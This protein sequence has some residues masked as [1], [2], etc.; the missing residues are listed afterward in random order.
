MASTLKNNLNKILQ[1]KEQK[2]L[3][4]N[5]RQGVTILGVEGN[6]EVL[7]TSDANAVASNLAEGK[8]AYV[9]GEK[10]TGTLPVTTGTYYVDTDVRISKSAENETMTVNG[11]IISDRILK[12]GS[13]ASVTTDYDD[14]VSIIGLRADEIKQGVKYLNVEGSF[15]S[16]DTS[17]A[18]AVA[19]DLLKDKIA[20]VNGEK[21]TGTLDTITD[22][23]RMDASSVSMPI[24]DGNVVTVAGTLDK[25]GI[26]TDSLPVHINTTGNQIAAAVG[27]TPDII[28]VGTNVMG[29]EGTY[30]A[31]DSSKNDVLSVPEGATTA[32]ITQMLTSLDSLDTSGLTSGVNLFKDASQLKSVPDL[33]TGAMTSTIRMFSGCNNLISMG[34]LNL[35]KS[36]NTDYMFYNC[37][38][39]QRINLIAPTVETNFIGMFQGCTNLLEI[40]VLDYTRL[41]RSA[42][43]HGGSLVNFCRDCTS[44]TFAN[45]RHG[46]AY[47]RYGFQYSGAFYNCVNLL[48]FEG[49]RVSSVS[50]SYLMSCDNMF[51]NCHKLQ[52]IS[53]FNVYGAG[54]N[55]FCLNC[56]NLLG[57]TN[58]N[59]WG[60]TN[61]VPCNQAFRNC[62]NLINLP[63]IVAFR[64]YSPSHYVFGN[65][66]NLTFN[67]PVN[68][69][70][71][72]EQS[73][74]CNNSS[75]MFADCHSATDIHLRLVNT[76]NGGVFVH[77]M[78]Y[79]CYN[80]VNL[81]IE[82]FAS[83]VGFDNPFIG[84]YKLRT[85]NLVNTN[86]Q[87]SNFFRNSCVTSVANSMLNN[88]EPYI[89]RF[90]A[91]NQYCDCYNLVEGGVINLN[92]Y[93]GDNCFTNCYNLSNLSGT[94]F[95]GGYLVMNMFAN[96]NKLTEL[97]NF[98]NWYPGAQMRISNMVYGCTNLHTL[99]AIN[100][101][102]HNG[103]GYYICPFG[104]Y[105]AILN[106][107]APILHNLVNFGGFEG[108]GSGYVLKSANNAYAAP[109]IVGAPN[110]SYESLLNVTTN[111]ANLY[112]VYNVAEGETLAYPQLIR[113]EANQYNKLS[114]ADI[115]AVQSKGWNI[116][117][118]TI[119]GT[120]DG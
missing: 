26:L 55:N 29:I 76:P 70:Y 54:L 69:S 6:I 95:H 32:T 93:Q 2:I 96:C 66:Y 87:Q 50:D 105:S 111:L 3:P 16:L 43:S 85:V 94:Y 110:L 88:G 21:I 90:V 39:L 14:I 74:Y 64:F 75:Y 56:H 78:W 44:L 5:I 100:L 22:E 67:Q 71:M 60:S 40:P 17:D 109:D 23:I 20:Y 92:I 81:T 61:G 46:Y 31:E 98:I 12:H 9:N 51:A 37:S 83:V 38:N 47:A 33:S 58:V 118:H 112:V 104:H 18:T 103:T 53:H 62:Y 24:A 42:Y 49:M 114:E 72:Y 57:F 59:F 120:I 68:I 97:N 65:C 30:G 82:N 11:M 86:P 35:A 48:A 89:D 36:A 99:G 41:K 73:R 101:I 13:R 117:V 115:A 119:G 15:E 102:K 108:L 34:Q 113:M 52:T 91:Y 8:T 116:E 25:T 27:L 10:I 45:L 7:D 80:L 63:P 1:E 77:R 4:E 28:K 84:C 106:N 79:N 107:T 19:G